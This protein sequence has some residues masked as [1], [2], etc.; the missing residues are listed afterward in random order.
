VAAVFADPVFEAS[1]PRVARALGNRSPTGVSV[2]SRASDPAAPLQQALRG[3]RAARGGGLGRL[4]FSRR[5]ADVIAALAPRGRALAATGFEASRE[6]A[7]SPAVGESRIVLFA[8]HSVLNERRPELS[9]V[10]LSLLDRSGRS[11][12]GLLRLHDVYNLEL[13]SDLVVLSGCQTA[14]GKESGGEGLIGLRRAFMYAGAPRVVA[15]LW[16]VDDEST[17][18]L[19]KWFYRAMLEDGRRP[20]EALRAAQLEM[21]RHPRWSAPFYW[22]GFVLQGEWK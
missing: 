6:A 22:A 12:D 14:L 15:S 16:Q 7:T 21:A 4:P 20:A 5:E 11:Q 18:E 1:D 19:M 2:A 17:A 9:G 8:T 3:L 10:V 13:G